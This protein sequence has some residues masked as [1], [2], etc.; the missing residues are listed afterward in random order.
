LAFTLAG[1]HGATL[2]FDALDQAVVLFSPAQLRLMNIAQAL[3]VF[4][5]ALHLELANLRRVGEH[6]K[7]VFVG[8]AAQWLLL[9]ALAVLTTLVCRLPPAVALGLLL[10]ACCPGGSAATFLSLLARGNAA[11]AVATV[12]VAILLSAVLTPLLFAL[13]R[14]FAGVDDSG[15]AL[16]LDA[17]LVIRTAVAYLLLPLLAGLALRHWR[18]ALVA[19]IRGPLKVLLGITLGVF[20]IGAV[21]A[22]AASLRSLVLALTPLVAGFHALTLLGSWGLAR[23][24]RVADAERRAITL[25][26]GVSNAGLAMLLVFTFFGGNGAMAA[27]VAWW[28]VWR[29]LASG[30]LTLFWSRLPLRIA[31]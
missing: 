14:A 17:L 11:V 1:R 12:T 4:V 28:S 3:L 5:V 23:L 27:L 29:L 26:A 10:L 30:V 24:L 19:R 18:P 16:R 9:P 8:L 15:G 22:N 6:P 13:C 31:A 20:V 7:A 21:Q 2:M 25:S